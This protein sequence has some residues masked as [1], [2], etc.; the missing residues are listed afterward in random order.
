MKYKLG[1]FLTAENSV[2]L[3][4][5]AILPGDHEI[6]AVKHVKQCEV[7]WM[8]RHELDMEKYKLVKPNLHEFQDAKVGD[9]VKMGKHYVTILARIDKAVLLS[10]AV[11]E[12]ARAIIEAAES[13]DDALGFSFISKEH[14][15]HLREHTTHKHTHNSVDAWYDIDVMALMDWKLIR[16]GDN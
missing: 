10:Q 14:R 13:M 2:L 11:Q 4:I 8:T 6:Y 15:D 5:V 7:S 12:E 3:M 9:H 1:D 16:E